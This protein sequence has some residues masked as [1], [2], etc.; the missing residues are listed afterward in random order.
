MVY[1]IHSY[2]D[3]TCF[4]HIRQLRLLFV[5]SIYN[6]CFQQ[7][8]QKQ[9]IILLILHFKFGNISQTFFETK[10]LI[11]RTAISIY[12]IFKRFPCNLLNQMENTAMSLCILTN[13]SIRNIRRKEDIRIKPAAIVCFKDFYQKHRFSNTTFYIMEEISV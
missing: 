6:L 2:V 8:T 10:I 1:Q 5:F 12:N 11:D 9:R 3:H 13:K 7:N 4:A